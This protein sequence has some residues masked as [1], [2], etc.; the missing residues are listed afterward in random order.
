[1]SIEAECIF[2]RADECAAV[3]TVD[4]VVDAVR[5]AA[6]ENVPDH[7]SDVA[8]REQIAERLY[9]VREL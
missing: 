5:N 9:A 3:K 7:G 4:V 6:Q 1:M 2:D 8:C